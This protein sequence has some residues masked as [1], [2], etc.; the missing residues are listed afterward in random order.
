V[1]ITGYYP[2]VSQSTDLNAIGGL[3]GIHGIPLPFPLDLAQNALV[4]RSAAF[5]NAAFSGLSALVSQANQGLSTPRVALAWPSFNTDNCYAA[6]ATYLF[7]VGD[8]AADETRGRYWLP[9]PG[10][11]STPQ[12]IAYYRGQYCSQYEPADQTCYDAC[13]GH[14]NALG[15]QAYADA[16]LHEIE[17]TLAPCLATRGLV[18]NP[19]CVGLRSQEST[20]AAEIRRIQAQLAL[21]GIEQQQC[22]AGIG[23]DGRRVPSA[24][25]TECGAVEVE[26]EKKALNA[27]MARANARLSVIENQKLQ[28]GCWY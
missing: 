5:A 20:A 25:P 17:T 26:A 14:P 6:P 12:G 27:S 19:A 23:P 11:W 10:D 1:V 15:A 28:A 3:L 24:K 13:M 18:E 4:G 2:I 9:P 7:K 21:M 16:I 8:F 22:Q